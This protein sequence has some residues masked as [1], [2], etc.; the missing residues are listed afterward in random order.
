MRS[1]EE[2]AGLVR[3]N[4]VGRRARIEGPYGR[5]LLTYADLTATGRFLHFVE[6]WIRQVHAFYANS[7]TAVSSTGRVMTELREEARRVIR[8][9]V[10]AGPD[11]VVLFVGSGATASIN[12][13]VGLLG[14]RIGEPLERRYHLSRHIPPN[15]RPV[16]LVGPYEHHSNEL[17]WLESV[18]EV[19][20]VE[21]D[22][23]G[24][25]DLEDLEARLK[26]FEARP[27]KLG[28]FSAASNVS[29]VLTDVG[30][31]A[32]L[33]HRYG[34]QACFDFAASGPYVPIDMHPEDPEE[35]LDA[36]MLSPH[37]FM[38]GPHASGLLV[39]NKSLVLTRTPERPGG[40][41]VDYVSG[42]DKESVDYVTRLDEREEGG[43]PAIVGDLR[44]GVAF[45]V[46]QMLGPERI[47]AHETALGRQALAR[48]SRHPRV[49]L[50]GPLDLP[51]LGIISFNIEGL[52]HDLVSALL[53]HLFGIQNRA[54]C[55]CAGPYGHRLLGI[56]RARS[57]RFRAQIQRGVLGI[58]P[59]WV[60]LS[61]PY[62]A[63]QDDVDFMLRAV[64][65]VADHGD[66]FVPVYRLGWLD[67]VWRHIE[68]SKVDVKPI[69]LTVEALLEA[70]QHFGA[71][72]HEQPITESQLKAEREQYF[73][74]ALR[75]A[76]LKRARWQYTPL[77]WNTPT[78]DADVDALVW[79]KYVHTNAPWESVP[80]TGAGPRPWTC[81]VP[82]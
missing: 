17:P 6:A 32:K 14:W 65:F 7:H 23:R 66:A 28:S 4:E 13:L 68:R 44:A 30:K 71:G 73:V 46:K 79:F 40:G 59:G 63:S 78:G 55:S 38:G 64:E 60:R 11:D 10:N 24:A 53:D 41:T 70:S 52:H 50:L 62:F 9:S 49:K 3:Q 69:E 27:F 12:K 31:V 39:V 26:Q 36:I 22:A 82:A 61:I 15:E 21:L 67:G 72:D 20:E 1:F 48:L 74:E 25:V 8:S 34:A 75:Y 29:G 77:K 33:L 18:A 56:D 35:R 43:T 76:E 81:G 2:V 19:H 5:R 54:G 51:R 16:V 47:L 58:K 37:K 57:E 80:P 45:L 42:F